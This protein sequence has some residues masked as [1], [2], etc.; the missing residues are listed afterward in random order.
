MIR[1]IAMIVAFTVLAPI[2]PVRA[3]SGKESVRQE[4]SENK[5]RMAPGGASKGVKACHVDIERWCAQVK[6][7]EGRLG[8]CLHEH[9]K[10]LSRSCRRWAA[11]GGKEHITDALLRDIDGL[12]TPTQK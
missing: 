1:V 6:P 10:E 12:P 2:Q 11:H 3:D 9:V 7:G 5:A 8:G 4:Q